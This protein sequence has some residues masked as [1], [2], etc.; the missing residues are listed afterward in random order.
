MF[1]VKKIV[2]G[3]AL[4]FAAL[5]VLLFLGLAVVYIIINTRM[6]KTY[7]VQAEP[8]SIRFDSAAV[9]S[10]ERLVGIRA[11][12][13]CHGADLGG[14]V[15]VDDFPIGTFTVKNLTRGKGGLPEDFG[16]DDWV[17]A[18]KHGLRGD[19]TPL[20]L[21]PSHEL[22]EMSEEDMADIIAYCSQLP[23]VDR[24][25]PPFRIGPLAYVLSAFDQIPL[26]PAE[27]T[28]HYKPFA[29]KVKPAATKEYGKYLAVMC[30]NC[31]GSNY[32][33]G[34]SPVPGGKFRPDITAAGNPGKWT[35]EQFMH[36]L[37]TGETPEG[38]RMNPGDMP[39]TI[40]KNYNDTELK[41]L[42]LYLKSLP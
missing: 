34:E 20:R 3:I 4:A 42:H 40:T 21:M 33:G 2:K 9:A 19:G 6:N 13:E 38:K 23:K 36:A 11:C 5:I 32:K 28:D 22:S 18:M 10:G 31:H 8:I 37:R 41:A 24:E 39:W 14:S 12:R 35:H 30:I 25:L 15:L 27:N 29:D 17:L 7:D 16:V 1:M 26:L